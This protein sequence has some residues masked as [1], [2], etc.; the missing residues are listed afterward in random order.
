MQ[1]INGKRQIRKNG[2]ER[3]FG[4]IPKWKKRLEIHVEVES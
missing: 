4:K 2:W 3:Q 1:T